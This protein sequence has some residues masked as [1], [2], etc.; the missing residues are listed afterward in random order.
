MT[1]TKLRKPFAK[2]QSGNGSKLVFLTHTTVN[3]SGDIQWI[4]HTFKDHWKKVITMWYA[5]RWPEYYKTPR[6]LSTDDIVQRWNSMPKIR[7][8][9]RSKP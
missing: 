6:K 4:G 3:K 2:I 7:T 9:Q 8:Y 1:W 5:G